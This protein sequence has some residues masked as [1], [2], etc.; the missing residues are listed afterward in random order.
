MA[1]ETSSIRIREHDK[2]RIEQLLEE[3]TRATG[4][5]PTQQETI[6]RVV[7]F[8]SGHRDAF[9][10]GSSWRPLDADEIDHWLSK[11]HHLGAWS[12]EDIDDIVYGEEA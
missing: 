2:E 5:R 1:A 4:S 8:V 6:E 7:D 3:I 9:V 11:G 12:T 10:A